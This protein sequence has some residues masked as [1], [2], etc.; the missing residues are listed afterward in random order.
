M[1]IRKGAPWGAPGALD[2][3]APV[4]VDDAS[5]RQHLQRLLDEGAPFGE[6]GLTGGD[7]HRTLGSPHHDEQDLRSGRGV[8]YPVDV[9]IASLDGGGELVFLSHLVAHPRRRVRWWSRRT[10]AVMNATH[11]GELDLGPRAHPGDGRLDLTDGRL[12]LGQRRAGRRRARSGTHLPH[13]DLHTH[14]AAELEVVGDGGGHLH[15]WLD[16]SYAGT[17]S[18]IE[19]TCR[20]DAVVVVA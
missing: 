10:V 1:T 11:L 2:P 18:R 4:V 7:L 3:A 15:V 12:P 9:G 16:G 17:A 8:R 14:S 20:A 13:P 19:V 6:L 5:A